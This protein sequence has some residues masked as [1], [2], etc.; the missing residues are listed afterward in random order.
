[1][2]QSIFSLIL[3]GAANVVKCDVYQ[4][5][6]GNFRKFAI[7]TLEFDDVALTL[8]MV[9]N[10]PTPVHDK[11]TVYGNILDAP[12]NAFIS[13]DVD[14]FRRYVIASGDAACNTS[15]NSLVAATEPPYAVYG[16]AFSA[17]G[18]QGNDSCGTVMSVDKDGFFTGADQEFGYRPSSG[19]HGMALNKNN[20][21]LY[22]AD[23]TGNFV[24]THSVDPSTGFVTFVDAS[25]APSNG[26]HG[27]YD[28]NPRHVTVHPEGKFLYVLFE[29]SEQL[30]QF[31]IDQATGIPSFQ[32][33]AYS[34]VLPGMLTHMGNTDTDASDPSSGRYAAGV[35]LSSSNK[36]LWASFRGRQEDQAGSFAAFSLNPDGSIIEQLF[37]TPT[38]S[39][40]GLSNI[41]S[42]N[43]ITDKYVAITDESFGFVDIFAL[44]DDASKAS[45]VARLSIPDGGC[46]AD[47]LWASRK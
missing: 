39:S 3:L 40:G 46:C 45:P 37:L 12:N 18:A 41:V 26:S 2:R 31:E 27:S 10:H 43:P 7:Y 36:Y 15:S 4:M 6:V 17:A 34:M 1:M 30:A 35:K 21:F 33:V 14:N 25:P 20:T 47:V 32:G 13:Y 38:L 22:S 28:T 29:G 42:P 19:I 24:W 11:K 9:G 23:D 8:K 5:L 44:A 16:T